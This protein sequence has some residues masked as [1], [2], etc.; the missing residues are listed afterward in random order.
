MI[1][2]LEGKIIH[3]RLNW[4]ILKCQSI[5]YKIFI[6]PAQ[7]YKENQ[8]YSLYIYEHIREDK[9]DLY[10]FKT[11]KEL[12]IF[13]ILLSVSGLGPKMGLSILTS[14]P[15]KEIEKAIEEADVKKFE[16]IKGIGKKLAAKIILELKNKVDFS[17]IDNK[18]YSNHDQEL[19]DA[20]AS[21]GYKKNEITKIISTL[22]KDLKNLEEKIRWALG[23]RSKQ[24][25]ASS[26]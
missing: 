18:K 16:K 17:Q 1:A 2:Y 21:L 13:E 9:N 20:L 12:E 19:E 22:P 3:K 24:H 6:I 15:V 5:G 8:G 25:V 4:I 11:I 26:M 23:R 14:L 7:K 10:G